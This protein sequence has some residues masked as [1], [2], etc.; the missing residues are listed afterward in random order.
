MSDGGIHDAS[1]RLDRLEV[2]RLARAFVISVAVHLLF[3]GAYRLNARYHLVERLALPAWLAPAKRVALKPP[4]KAG[5]TNNVQREV[6]LLFVDVSPA[7]ASPEAPKEAKYYSS[8]NSVAANPKADTESNTPKIEGNQTRIVKTETVR[9]SVAKP[10][11]PTL[12]PEPQVKP[13]ERTEEPVE[14]AKPRPTLAPGDLAMAKPGETARLGEGQ[15]EHER[16]R[17][18]SQVPR[19]KRE[20]LAQYAGLSGEKMKQDGGVKRRA[21][22]SSLDVRA[23]PFGAYDAAI[24]A[25]VQNRWYYLIDSGSFARDA[26]GRVTLEFKLHYDGRVTDVKVTEN[27]VTEL[28]CLLCQKAIL[29]P[30]PY[31]KWPS[32]MRRMVGA[33]FRDVTFTFYYN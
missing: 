23:T 12:A 7:Q 14:E 11:Q 26:T 22:T 5:Q 13:T 2:S 3:V 30:S 1:L 25:A 19:E 31:E 20:Q 15:A 27:T 8:L 10:L 21:L 29:D 24:I 28:L 6:P 4:P 18:L 17:R 32:D 16:P 9:P 33:D